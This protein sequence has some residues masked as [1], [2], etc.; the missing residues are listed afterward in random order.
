LPTGLTFPDLTLPRLTRPAARVLPRAPVNLVVLWAAW[1]PSC[2]TEMPAVQRLLN[3]YSARGLAAAGIAI[4]LPDDPAE[5]G[6]IE[7]FVARTRIAFPTFL[8]DESAYDQLDALCRRAGG[9]GV[10]LP[11]VFLA[12]AGGKLLAVLSGEELATLPRVLETHLGP[13]PAAP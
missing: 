10:V 12:D 5:L 2:A 11:T 3:A 4:H 13:P 9:E 8:V 6:A 7:R 1:C